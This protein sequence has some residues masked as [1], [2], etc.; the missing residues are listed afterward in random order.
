MAMEAFDQ[1]T[2]TKVNDG[3]GVDEETLQK[4]E[5]NITAVAEMQDTLDTLEENINDSI[6]ELK[7]LTSSKVDRQGGSGLMEWD[8]DALHI[9]ATKNG[10][11][12][13][14]EVGGNG[15]DFKYGSSKENARTV[16]K[17][18]QNALEINETIVFSAMQIGNWAWTV[19]SANGGLMM[20]WVG[21]E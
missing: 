3:Q 4:I 10:N 5:D 16:A 12:Y 8:D 11:Y 14:T 17:I 18:N 7:E 19:D 15:I 6:G 20:Q 13:E 1:V 21:E 2:L 9:S